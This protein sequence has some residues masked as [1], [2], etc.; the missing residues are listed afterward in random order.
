MGIG[1]T[2]LP[3]AK[4][5][6]NLADEFSHLIPFIAKANSSNRTSHQRAFLDDWNQDANSTNRTSF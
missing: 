1:S 4:M 6:C 3:Y 2:V 5:H